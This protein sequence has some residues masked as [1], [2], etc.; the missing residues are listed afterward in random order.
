MKYVPFAATGETVSQMCLGTMMFGSR[1]DQS[2]ADRIL[3]AA[4]ERGITFID[5]A[6]MYGDGKTEEILG[7]ILK[8][9]RDQLFITT[10]VHAGIDGDTIRTSLDASLKRMQ[11]ETVDLYMIHWPQSG[12][13]PAE[14]MQALNDVVVQGKA[15]H[16]GFCN[17]PAWLF[18]H[19]NTIAAVNGW[20]RLIC[21]QVPYNLFERGIEVEVLPQAVAE[22]IAITTYRA[23]VIGLLAGKYAAAQ[24]LPA[25]TRGENDPRVPAWLAKYGDGI[26]KLRKFSAARGVPMGHVAT[27]WVYS[28][29]GVTAPIVGVSTLAQTLTAIDGFDLELTPA[30]ITEIE[31]YF[32][33]AIKMEA[34]G[35]FPERRQELNLIADNV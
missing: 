28:K 31:S 8:G 10:K 26:E 30:E 19:Y 25:N 3:G 27:A 34:G 21:N 17:C 13:H 9:R 33:T 14:M 4:V 1:T 2:E 23:L 35:K 12:M 5:T 18:A 11:I 22:R 20:A 7:E 29:Q 15:R 24:P 16:V 32:D 6:A